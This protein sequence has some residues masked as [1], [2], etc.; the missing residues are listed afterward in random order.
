MQRGQLSAQT[1]TSLAVWE[2]GEQ[3]NMSLPIDVG[4]PH[5]CDVS[6]L[7]VHVVL[8]SNMVHLEHLCTIFTRNIVFHSLRG[9]SVVSYLVTILQTHINIV[10]L[11]PNQQFSL[12]FL[13]ESTSFS[14][15]I[16]IVFIS[17]LN[18]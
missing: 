9:S 4:V 5:E 17:H 3:Q 8:G 14:I 11:C 7:P 15:I 6:P 18:V 1:S 16:A 2:A 12:T 13:C 10:F